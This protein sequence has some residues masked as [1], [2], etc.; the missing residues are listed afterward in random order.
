MMHIYMQALV[1]LTATKLASAIACPYGAAAEAGLLSD[2]DVAKYE[3]VKRDGI[4]SEPFTSLHKK[5]AFSETHDA[6]NVRMTHGFLPITI[7]S[8]ALPLG[9]GLC[10]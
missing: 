9:G 7:P 10:E 1:A 6:L 5:E 8:L 4:A 2:A 3:A